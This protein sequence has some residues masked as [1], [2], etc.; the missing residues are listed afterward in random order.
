L[1]ERFTV[2]RIGRER[3]L[4]KR[5]LRGS[6]KAEK[7]ELEISAEGSDGINTRSNESEEIA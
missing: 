5:F 1:K 4:G 6:E 3:R 7:R 2:F